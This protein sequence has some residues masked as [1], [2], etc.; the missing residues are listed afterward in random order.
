MISGGMFPDK[1]DILHSRLLEWYRYIDPSLSQGV[2]YAFLCFLY[3]YITFINFLTSRYKQ[4]ECSV[5][6]SM[7]VHSCC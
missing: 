4:A 1:R 7:I 2:Y 5:K 6:C 3:L